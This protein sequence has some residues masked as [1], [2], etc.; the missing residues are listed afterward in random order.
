MISVVKIILKLR[1]IVIGIRNCVC[2]VFLNSNGIKLIKVVKLVNII[3]WKCVVFVILIVLS[4]LLFFLCF[5]LIKLIS[6]SELFI[7]MFIK[8]NMLSKF[9]M[10]N[11]IFII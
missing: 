9:I 5:L 3:G 4:K 10:V 7:I 8:V 2:V 11:F 6:I 1:F